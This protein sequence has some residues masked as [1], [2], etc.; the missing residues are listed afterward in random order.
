[1]KGGIGDIGRSFLVAIGSST[2]LRLKEIGF[3]L[4]FF[5]LSRVFFESPLTF[6]GT[7]RR[8]LLKDASLLPSIPN[9]ARQ[10][11]SFYNPSLTAKS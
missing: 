2:R 5:V 9:T 7:S 11:F 8:R 4:G 3:A 6:G 10:V 1:M